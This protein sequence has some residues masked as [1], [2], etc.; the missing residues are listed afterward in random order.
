MSGQGGERAL[1]LHLTWQ[2]ACRQC[3]KQKSRSS[4]TSMLFRDRGK[5]QK[6]HRTEV[7]VIASEE[8]EIAGGRSLLFLVIALVVVSDSFNYVDIQLWK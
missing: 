5:C 8:K 6:K 2:E 7:K 3:L 1:S 4:K